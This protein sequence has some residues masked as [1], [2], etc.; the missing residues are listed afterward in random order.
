MNK[1]IQDILNDY[2]DIDDFGRSCFETKKHLLEFAEEYHQNKL[3]TKV[4]EAQS[5]KADAERLDWINKE[6]IKHKSINVTKYGTEM[7]SVSTQH[8]KGKD[9]RDLID[10]AINFKINKESLQY[11][12]K[13]NLLNDFTNDIEKTIYQAMKEGKK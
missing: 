11:R 7:F 10:K 3:F 12:I 5:Y 13:E 9:I 4:L 6:L 2:V 8:I 1:S